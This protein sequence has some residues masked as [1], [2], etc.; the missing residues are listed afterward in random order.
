MNKEQINATRTV[1]QLK[2][3]IKE[4]EKT[5]NQIKEEDL[6]KFD[7]KTEEIKQASISGVVEFLDLY[8]ALVN[9]V[10]PLEDVSVVLQSQS[11]VETSLSS[12]TTGQPGT[13]YS[14]NLEG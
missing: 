7:S 6:S 14:F 13:V 5:R 8:G 3:N 12:S 11:M 9:P 10:N 1:Q 2:A 4:L